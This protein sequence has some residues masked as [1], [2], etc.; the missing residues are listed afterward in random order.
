MQKQIDL[1]GMKFGKKPDEVLKATAEPIDAPGH[2]QIE[3]P[4]GGVA[5]QAIKFRAAVPTLSAAYAM[6]PIDADDLAAHAGGDLAQ[7]ALLVRRSLL[8][9]RDPKI[10]NSALHRNTSPFCYQ[11]EYHNRV[12]KQPVFHTLNSASINGAFCWLFG[13][14]I[15]RGF[16]YTN[17]SRARPLPHAGPITLGVPDLTRRTCSRPAASNVP[18]PSRDAKTRVYS[19]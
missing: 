9:G 7:F 8:G 17:Q 4:L 2:D 19:L 18:G 12:Q 3:L 6:V 16:S 14:T 1:Q 5:T 11:R 10:E 13:T 15:S